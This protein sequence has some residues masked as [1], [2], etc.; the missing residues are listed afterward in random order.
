MNLPG[1]CPS[2]GGLLGFSRLERF[3]GSSPGLVW[4]G[5]SDRGVEASAKTSNTPG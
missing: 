2:R 3:K 1:M 5:L 4:R